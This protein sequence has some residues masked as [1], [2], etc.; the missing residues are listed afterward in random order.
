[1]GSTRRRLAQLPYFA[2]GLATLIFSIIWP[3]TLNATPFTL[4]IPSPPISIKTTSGYFLFH[5]KP[6]LCQSSSKLD[7]AQTGGCEA[8]MEPSNGS[9]ISLKEGVSMS[10]TPAHPAHV[11]NPTV[12]AGLAV[13]EMLKRSG[14]ELITSVAVGYEVGAR[15]ASLSVQPRSGKVKTDNRINPAIPF[16]K[17]SLILAAFARNVQRV[18]LYYNIPSLWNSTSPIPYLLQAYNGVSEARAKLEKVGEIEKLLRDK[19]DYLRTAR[20]LLNE[21]YGNDI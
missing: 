5:S 6:K 12:A 15:V 9:L 20:Q 17:V 10:L 21:K 11:G 14:K 16:P 4:V 7:A 19:E 3:S 8:V 1:M 18:H 2:K 13:C